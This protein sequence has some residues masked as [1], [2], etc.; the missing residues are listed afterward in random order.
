[1][2]TLTLSSALGSAATCAELIREDGEDVASTL[3]L[4]WLDEV[5]DFVVGRALECLGGGDGVRLKLSL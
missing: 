5:V 1:M 3:S 2:L 4:W